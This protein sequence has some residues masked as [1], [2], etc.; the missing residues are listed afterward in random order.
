MPHHGDGP[1]RAGGAHLGPAAP[2]PPGTR[3]RS[4]IGRLAARI[5]CA[6]LAGASVCRTRRAA[7]IVRRVR[8]IEL[9]RAVRR[10]AAAH[11]DIDLTADGPVDCGRTL[12][13]NRRIDHPEQAVLLVGGDPGHQAGD[14]L[15]P[16]VHPDDHRGGVRGRGQRWRRLALTGGRDRGDVAA[17]GD[18]LVRDVLVC[19]ALIC[20]MLVGDPLVGHAFVGVRRRGAWSVCGHASLSVTRPQTQGRRMDRLSRDY[21][22][23]LPRSG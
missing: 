12:G 10:A 22:M 20:D 6:R 7:A 16:A 1:G 14:Q 21:R 9:V 17:I 23:G 13:R 4:A 2:A 8:R 15:G 3:R 19:D 5:L 18:P 11:P